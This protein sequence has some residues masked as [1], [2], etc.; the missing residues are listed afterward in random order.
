MK[1]AKD[2]I[3]FQDIYEL[4]NHMMSKVKD[5]E[6][7]VVANRDTVISIMREL[8]SVYTFDIDRIDID[9]EEEYFDAYYVNL[10]IDKDTKRLFMSIG[11][12]YNEYRNEYFGFDGYVM[13][14]ECVNSR[15]MI[16]LFNN[17]DVDVS[18]YD[19]FIIG[20]DDT[21]YEQES[22][23]KC[24]NKLEDKDRISYLKDDNG[25]IHGFSIN[26]SNENSA[27]SYSFYG[28]DVYDNSDII[29]LT[30]ALRDFLF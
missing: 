3:R 25:D 14:D 19:C 23:C 11:K 30:A 1:K 16:D 29:N 8:I 4:C 17:E 21:E 5:D 28:T 15:A 24:K 9:F 20:D 18:D 26:A 10:Y 27:Y 12:G 13:F 22:K 7:T 2:M 6:V